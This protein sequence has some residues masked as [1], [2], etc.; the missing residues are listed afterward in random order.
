MISATTASNFGFLLLGVI[1]SLT[2]VIRTCRR[3][4]ARVAY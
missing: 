4:P 2:A 1:D 3:L